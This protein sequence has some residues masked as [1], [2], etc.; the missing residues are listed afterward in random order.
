[1]NF[2][3]LVLD[4]L[5]AVFREYNLNVINQSENYVEFAS[6]KIVITIRHNNLENSNL[7]FVG[8]NLGSLF[9]MDDQ[10]I[11]NIF[12]TTL[13]FD[14]VTPEI[15]VNN[16]YEFFKN[17]G[18]LFLNGDE[19]TLKSLE[20]YVYERSNNYT[21]EL[22]DRQNMRSANKAWEEN[23]YKDF[24]KFISK[25]DMEKLLPSYKLKYKMAL[26]RISNQ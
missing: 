5:L 11:G 7:F 13:K 23:N 12:K 14:F 15:F 1:M 3:K 17:E 4:K 10:I 25:I 6:K 20:S 2:N 24:V 16:L 18:I 8:R 19:K 21:N 9:L 22:L 26:K